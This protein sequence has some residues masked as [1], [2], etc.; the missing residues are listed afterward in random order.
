SSAA[1]LEV[2]AVS[3]S[4]ITKYNVALSGT[5]ATV[6]APNGTAS[7]LGKG[8]WAFRLTDGNL[9]PAVYAEAWLHGTDQVFWNLKSSTGTG[10]MFLDGG[11]IFSVSGGATFLEKD[12]LIGDYAFGSGYYGLWL[13]ALTGGNYVATNQAGTHSVLMSL[14]NV[15]VRSDNATAYR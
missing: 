15:A 2:D 8:D 11:A 10:Q 4:T 9:N 3:G 14:S 7:N 1:C 13:R 6:T 12:S 5:T